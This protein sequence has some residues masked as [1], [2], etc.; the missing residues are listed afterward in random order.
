[1]IHPTRA[2]G[3]GLFGGLV[4]AALG[5]GA[6]KAL[7]SPAPSAVANTCSKGDAWACIYGCKEQYGSNYAGQCSTDI[8]GQ[9][10][11]HCY[12]MAVSSGG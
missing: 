3:R 12:Q 1:V 6:T 9:V 8:W 7:A 5:F 4:V 11:C 2:L 10:T